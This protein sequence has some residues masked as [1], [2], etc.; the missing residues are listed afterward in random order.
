MT[1]ILALDPAQLRDW[2]ALA[3]IDMQYKV[4]RKRFEYSLVAMN[5]KQA[6]PYDQIVDWVIKALKNPAFNTHSPPEFVLDATGVGVAVND[7]FRAKH[8]RTKAVTITVGNGLNREGSII[9][10][11]KARLVGKFLGAFDAGK[12]HVNPDMPIWPAVER[13]MLSF[14]AEMSAQGRVKLEAEQG[15]HDD[16]LFALALCIWYGEEILRGGKL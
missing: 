5:R 11:G 4:E 15:E 9:H 13:E 2:S 12:V 1:F 8:I 7:M 10:L 6:L 14:R 16:M 3:A